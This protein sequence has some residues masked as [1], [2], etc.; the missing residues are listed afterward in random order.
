MLF[1]RLHSLLLPA[2]LRYEW[3]RE[4]H[5][6]SYAVRGETNAVATLRFL[7]GAWADV[8]A[9]REAAGLKWAFAWGD[10]LSLRWL[11]GIA[12]A[13]LMMAL[14]VPVSRPVLLASS[15]GADGLVL[16]QDNARVKISDAEFAEWEWR[17]KRRLQVREAAFY[18][19]SVR[20]VNGVPMRVAMATSNL[21]RVL[22]MKADAAV[23]LST[24]GARRLGQPPSVVLSGAMHDV[25]VIPETTLRL[26][27]EPE[28]F[29]LVRAVPAGAR[30]YG[31]AEKVRRDADQRWGVE[32]FSAGGTR[33]S[34]TYVPLA[35]RTV[36][37]WRAFFIALVMTLLALPASQPLSS[38][39]A[40]LEHQD[41]DRVLKMRAAGF[42]FLQMA[43]V[44]VSSGLVALIVA[45]IAHCSEPTEESLFQAVVTF[46]LALPLL[47]VVLHG[48]RYRCPH[49]LKPLGHAAV[50]GSPSASFLDWYGV[51]LVCSQGHGL[52][53]VPDMP[54]TWFPAPRWVA[55]D[56]SWSE[57]FS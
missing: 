5:A 30:G 43:L 15:Y 14:V 47:R 28:V 27:E 8:W 33:I 6:E 51:E 31:V 50:V 53:H 16:M 20:R 24:E 11:S 49:C 40:R 52:V 21:M 10:L 12:M 45:S 22:G 46:A 54:T 32:L 19:V 38:R 37:P 55:L 48:H 2:R 3:L 35:T 57:L 41:L 36:V 56:A 39:D 4:W 44:V 23:V 29:V 17:S 13:L 7:C 42:L 1:L 34:N 26:P 9:V 25:G 18:S